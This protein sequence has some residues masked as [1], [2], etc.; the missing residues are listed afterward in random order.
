MVQCSISDGV[1][2]AVLGVGLDSVGVIL[3]PGEYD[4]HI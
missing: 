1:A 2:N 4:G 3:E